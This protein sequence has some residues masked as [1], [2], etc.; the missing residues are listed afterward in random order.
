MKLNSIVVV[1]LLALVLLTSVSASSVGFL[2]AKDSADN[3]D[4]GSD[5]KEKAAESQATPSNTDPD[6]DNDND[7]SPVATETPTNPNPNPTT[8]PNPIPEQPVTGGGETTTPTTPNTPT[9]PTTPSEPLQPPVTTTQP[10]TTP[11]TEKGPDQSCLFHPEQAKCKSDNGKCPAGF[12]QNEDGNCFPKH[13]KCPKGFHSHEDD[14][15][16]RCIS[17]NIPC[18]EGYIRD[19]NF[20]TCSSKSFLCKDH[21]ELKGCGNNAPIRNCEGNKCPPPR[22]TPQ[23]HITI[24]LKIIHSSNSGKGYSGSHGL[25]DACYLIIKQTWL[26]NIHIGQNPEIDKFMARCFP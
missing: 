8:N 2:M 19:P 9:T 12:N 6:K 7:L 25:S 3:S 15:T 20:P 24:I 14:E 13:D 1:G 23:Q 4:T 10:P 11:T 22:I 21:P 16:G 5:S 26:G 17:D 18:Q